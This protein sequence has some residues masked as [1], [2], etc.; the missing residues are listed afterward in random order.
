[1]EGPPPTETAKLHKEL[2]HG[3]TP[4]CARPCKAKVVVAV[5]AAAAVTVAAV[6]A[7]VV[8]VVVVVATVTAAPAAVAAVTAVSSWWPSKWYQR[9]W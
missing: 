9:Y 6:A 8:V 4:P 2:S 3:Y 5:T 7:T 1:V